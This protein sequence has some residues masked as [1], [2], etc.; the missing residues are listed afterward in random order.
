[1]SRM[2]ITMCV[3]YINI[4]LYVFAVQRGSHFVFYMSTVEV[5]SNQPHFDD[6]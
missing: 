5:G 6:V 4:N 1:M 2:N 3:W